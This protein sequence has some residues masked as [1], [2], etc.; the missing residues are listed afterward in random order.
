MTVRKTQYLLVKCRESSL[1]AHG[2]G[3]T[4]ALAVHNVDSGW[5]G[6]VFMLTTRPPSQLCVPSASGALLVKASPLEM[7]YLQKRVKSGNDCSRGLRHNSLSSSW[8]L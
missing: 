3:F 5:L 4:L 6:A 8:L 7:R 1:D 2:F